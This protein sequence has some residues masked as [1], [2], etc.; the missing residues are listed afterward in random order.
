MSKGARGFGRVQRTLTRRR[1]VYH[2]S[3]KGKNKKE[4]RSESF[5]NSKN[6]DGFFSSSR[7]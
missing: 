3:T 6:P 7:F 5:W 4:V 1:M 2:P